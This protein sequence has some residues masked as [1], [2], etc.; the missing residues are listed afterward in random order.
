MTCVDAFKNLNITSYQNQLRV[1]PCCVAPTE[2]TD[3]I[4]F[5]NNQFLASI[6]TEWQ[7]G[8]WPNACASC[9]K[10][11]DNMYVSRRQG[12]NKWYQDHNLDNQT[13]ELVRIDYWT[14]DLCNLACVICG[15]DFSSVWKQEL[16]VSVNQKVNNNQFWKDLDLHSLRFLHFNGGE[17]LISKEHVKFLKAIP[18]KSKVHINY[19]TNGTVR[20]SQE[21][22]ELWQEFELV[23]LDFSIDDI[24]PRFEYQRYPAVWADVADNLMWFVD[25]APHNCMFG[26][27]TTVSILNQLTLSDLDQWLDKNFAVSR[28]QDTI[29]HR[30][31]MVV[32][33]LAPGAPVDLQLAWLD[34][35]DARRGTDW[36]ITFPEL[37]YKLAHH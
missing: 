14:G 35:C 30:K 4:D 25:H 26:V 27:N 19:N 3:T 9:K 22:L 33:K 11:E 21:L 13:V 36:R 2:A 16:G 34:A 23:Q 5:A 1:G 12:A 17:P 6:R 31:Q 20:P 8:N 32:G 7:Q 15:P 24:G 29:E 37:V 10:N 18:V 28:F